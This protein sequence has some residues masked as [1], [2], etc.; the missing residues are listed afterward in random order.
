MSAVEMKKAALEV[1]GE[2]RVLELS[3]LSS[4][5]SSDTNTTTTMSNSQD[6]EDTNVA[7]PDIESGNGGEVQL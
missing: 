1:L 6:T 5:T 2:E 3:Q 7:V 4:P